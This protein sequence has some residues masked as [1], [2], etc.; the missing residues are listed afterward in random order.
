MRNKFDTYYPKKEMIN[1]K[2][3]VVDVSSQNLG[4]VAS[5]IA[6]VLRGKNKVDFQPSVDVGDFVVAINTDKLKIS[7]RKYTDKIYYWH[8]GYPGGIKQQN[9]ASMFQ[10]DS[11][12]VLFLAVKRMLPKGRIGSAMLRKLYLYPGADHKHQ[13]QQPV[14]LV[15]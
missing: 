5:Q 15:N 13:A 1:K 12:K 6:S 9:F 11:T 8:T 2:W 3:V 4:R 14:N 7:G 10:K